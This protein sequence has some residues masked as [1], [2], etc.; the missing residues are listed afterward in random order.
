M[1][2]IIQYLKSADRNKIIISNNEVESVSYLDVGHQLSI[3]LKPHLNNK[4]LSM[5]AKDMVDSMM[6]K[7]IFHS[8]NYGKVIGIK[9]IGILLEKE[10]KLNFKILIDYYSQ[11]HPLFIKWDGAIER[12]KLYF[13]TKEKGLEIDISELSHIII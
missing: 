4:H 5:K 2:D 8:D 3:L 1:Q 11:N 7:N 10:L 6:R 12:D 13:L 9:N